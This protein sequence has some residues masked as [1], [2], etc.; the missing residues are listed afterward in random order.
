MGQQSMNA[1]FQVDSKEWRQFGN[2]IPEE[3]RKQTSYLFV[4]LVESLKKSFTAIVENRAVHRMLLTIEVSTESLHKRS[5]PELS[6]C[7][8]VLRTG[9]IADC[10]ALVRFTNQLSTCGCLFRGTPCQTL[11]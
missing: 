9:W 3:E 8:V 11:E 7:G 5:S 6:K 2:G 4:C 10:V 1:F